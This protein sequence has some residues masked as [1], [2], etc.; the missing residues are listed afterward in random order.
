MKKFSNYAHIVLALAALTALS[1]CN[2]TLEIKDGTI[3]EEFVPYVQKYLGNYHGQIEHRPS[4]LNISLESN[5]LVM[6][7]TDDMIAPACAS[8]IGNL[9]KITYKEEKDKSITITDA[10]FDF[11]PNLCGNDIAG[12]ELH[13][14]AAKKEPLTLDM[15]LLDHREW[16]WRCNG[17]LGRG[18]FPQPGY[19]GDRCWQEYYGIYQTGRFVRQ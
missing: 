7:S 19:P 2:Q 16:G 8:R 11:D 13:F 10:Y 17:N 1:A 3:P 14:T 12:R 4:G 18:P 9:K 15:T 5:R 6:K